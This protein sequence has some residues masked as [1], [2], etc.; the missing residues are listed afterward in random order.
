MDHADP[1][2]AA[3]WFS[4]FEFA[5]KENGT[6]CRRGAAPKP[7]FIHG[8]GNCRT[9]A[10]PVPSGSLIAN[11][12]PEFPHVPAFLFHGGRNSLASASA[13]GQCLQAAFLINVL[14]ADRPDD[15][16][17]GRRR[18]SFAA[19][20]P[21]GSLRCRLATISLWIAKRSG[22]GICT[23][24]PERQATGAG[25][26]SAFRSLRSRSDRACRPG[27][28]RGRRSS[29]PLEGRRA[30]PDHR[31]ISGFVCSA[32]SCW[33]AAG[34][35]STKRKLLNRAVLSRGRGLSSQFC[36]VA[37]GW[38]AKS[39]SPGVGYKDPPVFASPAKP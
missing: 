14:P 36:A 27:A 11:S 7:G 39:Q 19:L 6:N 5:R 4:V 22:R 33:S 3:V 29:A 15:A 23:R 24:T 28:R 32:G 1:L 35:C 31:L 38:A 12:T 34:V 2:R 21:S 9:V 10:G 37:P 8:S 16:A 18:R 26:G 17:S 30:K 20:N 13:F 25:T